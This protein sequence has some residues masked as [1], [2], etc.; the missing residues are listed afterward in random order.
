MISVSKDNN[1]K[2]IS[3]LE[4]RQVGQS[5]FDKFR[6]E[7]LWI[8]DLWIHPDYK[9]H[10]EVYRQMMSAALF[11]G[12]DAK[13]IYFKREKYAGRISKLYTRERIMK[14]IDRK[15][16]SLVKELI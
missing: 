4:W 15:S 16:V 11:K 2:V 10:W 14:L 6:G 8:N 12:I 3:Y 13:W 7:Y 5:G 1:E 9:D